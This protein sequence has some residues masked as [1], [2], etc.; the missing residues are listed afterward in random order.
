MDIMRML[1]LVNLLIAR[2]KSQTDTVA[3]SDKRQVGSIISQLRHELFFSPP[4]GPLQSKH[5]V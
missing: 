1:T 5:S 4:Y 3:S 2:Q